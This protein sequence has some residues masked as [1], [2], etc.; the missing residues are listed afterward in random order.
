MELNLE[1]LNKLLNAKADGIKCIEATSPA[2][3]MLKT[4]VEIVDIYSDKIGKKIVLQ[5]ASTTENDVE[6]AQGVF[7][8]LKALGAVAELNNETGE[9]TL[10]DFP[11]LVSYSKQQGTNPARELFPEFGED[12]WE[13]VEDVEFSTGIVLE[14]INKETHEP[15]IVLNA[16][17]DSAQ[18]SCVFS[19]KDGHH[20][21]SSNTLRKY[22][23][24]TNVRMDKT[25]LMALKAMIKAGFS[26][27]AH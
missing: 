11:S 17:S 24:L 12:T 16:N 3:A 14:P 19:L 13:M 9:L 20:H 22:Y 10:T 21:A 25:G 15:L 4:V 2:S 1:L 26:G 6:L 8:I 7:N 27:L 23:T 18:M 5:F